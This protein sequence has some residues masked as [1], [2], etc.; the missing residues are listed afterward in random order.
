MEGG[1]EEKGT[2]SCR[3]RRGCPGSRSPHHKYVTSAVQTCAADLPPIKSCVESCVVPLLAWAW[4]PLG[5]G[6]G[7]GDFPLVLY[8]LDSSAFPQADVSFS[9][10]GRRGGP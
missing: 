10:R 2:Y 3:W 6:W 8:P 9:A 5:S 4:S 7:R 1:S